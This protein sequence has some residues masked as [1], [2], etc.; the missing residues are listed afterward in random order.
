MWSGFI[1]LLYTARICYAL[2]MNIKSATFVKSVTNDQ[3]LIRD[4]LPQIA[5]VG[6]SNVGKSSVINSLTRRKSAGVSSVPGYTKA[7]QEIEIDSKVTLIDSPGVVV[8]SEDE[9]VLLLRNT[10]KADQ[11]VDLNRAIDEIL[12]RVQKENLVKRNKI[13]DFSDAN[14]FLINL[15]LKKKKIK[16]FMQFM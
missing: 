7:I 16:S 1:A 13:A 10:I 8:S 15:A 3:N 5:F 2:F 4:E 14:E 12:R 11:V 6:R 9:I